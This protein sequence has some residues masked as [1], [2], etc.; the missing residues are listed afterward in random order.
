MNSGEEQSEIDVAKQRKGLATKSREPNRLHKGVVWGIKST[1][2]EPH[3]VEKVPGS[4]DY[5]I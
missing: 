5:R 2:A 3:L 1:W 4:Q